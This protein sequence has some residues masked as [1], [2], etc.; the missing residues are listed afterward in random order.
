MK[1]RARLSIRYSAAVSFLLAAFA[2]AALTPEVKNRLE[3]LNQFAV[4]NTPS[5]FTTFLKENEVRLVQVLK[6]A[7]LKT[8]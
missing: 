6:D 7:G 5:E 3:Q 4:G 8:N 1:L 2:G